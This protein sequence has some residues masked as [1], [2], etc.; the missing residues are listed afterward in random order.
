MTDTTA[1]PAPWIDWVQ[2]AQRGDQQAFSRLVDANRNL[3]CTITLAIVRDVQRSEDVAQEVLLA[4]WRGLPR[5]RDPSSFLPW[6]RQ[7][8]R[9]RAHDS[10]RQTTRHRRLQ[11]TALCAAVTDT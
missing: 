3:V 10:L 7:L 11:G 6:L 9:N 2:A 8:A 1:C 5:L 4:V